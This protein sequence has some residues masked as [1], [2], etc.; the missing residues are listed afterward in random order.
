MDELQTCLSLQ[1]LPII[2]L[3]FLK[4]RQAC[5]SNVSVPQVSVESI[6]SLN[7]EAHLNTI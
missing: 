5:G 6:N 7:H 2:S 1:S 4:E 3:L